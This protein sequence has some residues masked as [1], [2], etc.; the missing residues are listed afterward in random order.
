MKPEERD[1]EKGEREREREKMENGYG[2][3]GVGPT[4][5]SV[6]QTFFPTFR[7]IADSY[8]VAMHPFHFFKVQ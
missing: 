7:L 4:Q 5:Y 2:G 3:G 6:K 8:F 1:R